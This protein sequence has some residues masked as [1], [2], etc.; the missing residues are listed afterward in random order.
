MNKYIMKITT[1][2]YVH[3]YDFRN[4]ALPNLPSFFALLPLLLEKL[5]NMYIAIA[6]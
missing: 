6:C 4:I 5:V 2:S 3:W 1:K